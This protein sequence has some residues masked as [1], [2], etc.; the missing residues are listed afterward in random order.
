[1]PALTPAWFPLRYHPTQSELWRCRSRFISLP[2]GRGSGKTMISKRRLAMYLGVDRDLSGERPANARGLKHLYAYLGPTRQWAKRVAWD[3]LKSLV[4]P[5]W[6]ARRGISESDLTIKTLWGSELHC[7]GMDK[8]ARFEG[9][10]WDGVVEDESS[11]QKPKIYLSIRPAISYKL[12]WW[13][14]I[15]IA[16]RYGCGAPDYRKQ[17]LAGMP[18]RHEDGRIEYRDADMRTFSWPSWD[19]IAPSEVEEMRKR[20]DPKDFNEQVGGQ[21]E[22]AGGAAFYRFSRDTHVHKQEYDP[23][24]PLIV[25]CDFNVS[26]MSWVIC[27]EAH[28][29]P[30]KSGGV[31]SGLR[32]L[33]EIWVKDTNTPAALDMVWTRYGQHR[34]GFKF[35]GDAAARQRHTSATMSDYALILN[36]RRFNAT[37]VFPSDNPAR[38]DR[39]ASC[40]ALLGNA[41][42]EIRCLI[43]PECE[44]LINDLEYRG[45]EP[46]GNPVDPKDAGGEIGHISD[47]WGYVVHEKWPS[48]ILMPEEEALNEIHLHSAV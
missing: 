19:I 48:T 28:D 24:R 34:G 25:T 2:S 46:D 26:P 45:L 36:D 43:D 5:A 44:Q 15:G 21:W 12:G 4:P 22:Q 32:C 31:L 10:Q 27:Q 41:A 17:C 40:N 8:P 29:I 35:Y 7:I 1:M 18:I 42:D 38:K 37:C 14:K 30:Q 13:W 20:M 16:K 11:D 39:L 23:N 6:I 9:D 3:D 47:A 33:S